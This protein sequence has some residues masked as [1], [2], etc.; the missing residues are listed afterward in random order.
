[1]SAE[2]C[3]DVDN[4]S[5]LAAVHAVEQATAKESLCSSAPAQQFSAL[6]DKV[7][8]LGEEFEIQS[9]RDR[10]K[11]RDAIKKQLPQKYL[12]ID[13]RCRQ[14]IQ[15]YMYIIF[16]SLNNRTRRTHTN[17][18]TQTHNTNIHTTDTVYTNTQH[19]HT[20]NTN[21][22]TYNIHTYTQTHIARDTATRRW[23]QDFKVGQSVLVKFTGETIKPTWPAQ[24][25]AKHEDRFQ[26]MWTQKNK[27]PRG[28]QLGGL[29]SVCAHRAPANAYRHEVYAYLRLFICVH[30]CLYE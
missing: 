29:Y 19:K 18:H 28:Q 26:V 17:I 25:V 9:I 10:K 24:L 20:H 27:I 23:N 13:Q 4:N 3:A 12:E 15:L 7:Q 1:M 14:S 22:H 21:I 8:D 5:L 11:L 2:F 16:T 30:V 6:Y